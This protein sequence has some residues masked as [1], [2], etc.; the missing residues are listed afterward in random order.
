MIK[1]TKKDIKISK[2]R[3]VSSREILRKPGKM[4]NSIKNTQDFVNN[5]TTNGQFR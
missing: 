3:Q 5:K 2:K 4:K 1:I